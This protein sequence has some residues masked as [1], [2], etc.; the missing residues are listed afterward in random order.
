MP[1][2]KALIR[3]DARIAK[4]QLEEARVAGQLPQLLRVRVEQVGGT[5]RRTARCR[6]RGAAD[7]K[8]LVEQPRIVRWPRDLAKTSA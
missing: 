8:N 2:R 7:A 1:C 5:A 6:Q 4:A 3:R